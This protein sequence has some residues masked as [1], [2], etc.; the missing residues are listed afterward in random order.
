MRSADWA[1]DQLPGLTQQELAQLKDCGITTTK[2]LLKIVSN[3]QSKLKLANHLEINVKYLHKWSALADL[4][5]IPS[6]GCQYSGLLL[7]SGIGSVTKLTQTPVD[8]LHKQILR[9]QVATLQRQDL[10]PPVE[11]VQKWLFEAKSLKD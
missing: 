10:C 1:I 5:R 8:K 4:A 11:T 3:P 2:K 6:V 9:L 7:H